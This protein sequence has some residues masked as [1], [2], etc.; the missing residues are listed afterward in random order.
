M[1][2]DTASVLNKPIA[3]DPDALRVR[4]AA[5]RHATSDIRAFELV[6]EH[7]GPLPGFTAGAHIGVEVILPDGERAHRSYSIASPPSEEPNSYLLGVLY[8]ESG[9]GGSMFM[10]ER[11]KTGY[12]LNATKPKN[13]FELIEGADH[14]ILIAGGIGI[15]PILAMAHTLTADGQSME[16]HYAARSEEHMAFRETVEEICGD[17]AHLYF[18]GGDPKQGV[19]IRAVLGA[20]QPGRHVYVCGPKGMIEAV[21]NTAELLRWPEDH[22]HF[23]VFTPPEA[24]PG[25]QPIE[26][27][28]RSTGQVLTVE[29]GT[30]I[31][32]ALLAAGV[33]SDY[34]CRMG[35]CGSCAVKVLE[36]EADNRDTVLTTSEHVEEKL[37]CTCVSWASTPKLVLDH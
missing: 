25:D 35:I 19:D 26:V 30:P 7:S 16:I 14:S 6:A 13:F 15:T 27:T 18:D 31:L 4:I 28:V 17:S 37:M 1:A 36:G 9:T 3:P 23:E 32:D 2:A 20:P 33:D 8:E 12:V 5:A 10:H 22:V 29:P 11:A 24:K 21:R 34:D